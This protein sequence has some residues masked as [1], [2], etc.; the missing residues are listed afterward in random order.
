MGQNYTF[1]C[2]NCKEYLCRICL[3]E[4]KSHINHIIINFNENKFKNKIKEIKKKLYSL[5][6][7][8]V[9][10]SISLEYHDYLNLFIKIIK[11]FDD[12]PSYNL[13]KC[14]NNIYDF[15]RK[16]DNKIILSKIKLEDFK[17]NNTLETN[18]KEL[19]AIIL[20]KRNGIP[21]NILPNNDLENLKKLELSN[22]NIRN[23]T[24]LLNINFH[25]L[26]EL[27]LSINRIDDKNANKIF[28]ID[29]PNLYYLNLYYNNLKKYDFFKNIH[30]FK[31]LKKLYIGLNEFNKEISEIDDNTIYD[32]SILEEIELP[33]K[34]FSDESID[35][36]SKFKFKN[37]KLLYLTDKFA[38]SLSI[39]DILNFKNIKILDGNSINSNNI[40]EFCPL[41]K[42]NYLNK[43]IYEDKTSNFEKVLYFLNIFSSLCGKNYLKK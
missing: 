26:K 42:F 24:P 2:Q 10:S 11:I 16:E 17:E 22:I 36:L 4:N 31:N 29:M 41:I 30:I 18:K 25:A 38:H 1:F 21:L 23:L 9:N 3:N 6:K 43:I 19:K 7:K 27:N 39:R 34:L 13:Y 5:N 32:C 12:Y 33:K 40:K 28:K 35:L 37:L 20:N 8:D 14:I 15:L